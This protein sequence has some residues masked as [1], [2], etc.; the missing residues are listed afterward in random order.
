M[1][2][3]LKALYLEYLNDY[4]TVDKIAEHKAIEVRH[5]KALISIGK[6]Y[7]ETDVEFYKLFVFMPDY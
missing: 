5:M 2:E 7:H 1:R 4:L 6:C 3:Q